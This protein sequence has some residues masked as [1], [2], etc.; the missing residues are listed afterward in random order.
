MHDL[1]SSALFNKKLETIYMGNAMADH[2]NLKNENRKKAS[3]QRG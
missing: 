3:R 2:V 1:N